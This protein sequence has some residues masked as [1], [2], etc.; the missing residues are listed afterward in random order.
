[1]FSWSGGTYPRSDQV[2][3]IWWLLALIARC[4]GGGDGDDSR[5][6]AFLF[7]LFPGRG[8]REPKG[9]EL[10]TSEPTRRVREL[11]PRNEVSLNLLN[12][13]WV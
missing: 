3:G 9:G 13:R 11:V 10:E 7:F 4:G 12:A 2:E 1:M 8:V 5:S 6:R